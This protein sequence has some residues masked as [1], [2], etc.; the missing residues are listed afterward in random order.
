VIFASFY[1][2]STGYVTG[3]L[4]P[5]FDGQKM[6]IEATGDR[7]VIV[8]DGRESL[9]SQIAVARSECAKRGYVG[10]VLCRG[11]TFTRAKPITSFQPC[12]VTP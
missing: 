10:F 3:S 8:L 11:D 6:P 7:S 1:Q 2:L 4:P 9:A 5:R 12:E